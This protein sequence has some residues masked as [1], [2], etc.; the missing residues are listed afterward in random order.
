[1]PA[2][3]Y[4]APQAGAEAK[5][6]QP[7]A[8]MANIQANL[9]RMST[10]C[11]SA[12]NARDFSFQGH[13]DRKDFAAAI[14]PKFKGH[15]HT[16]PDKPATWPEMV[17]MWHDYVAAEPGV[18]FEIIAA[19]ADVFANGTAVVYVELNVTGLRDGL[20]FIQFMEMKW[21]VLDGMWR[22]Y[23]CT[24]MVGHRAINGLV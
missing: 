20:T 14:S 21:R 10:A 13:P 17:H 12:F 2:A 1:M 19:S 24:T 3:R 23:S 16:S 8:A 9:R 15:V 11:V 6:S 5:G 22:Y 7:K 18:H 4:P